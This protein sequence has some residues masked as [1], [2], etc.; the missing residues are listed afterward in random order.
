MGKNKNIKKVGKK[1][2]KK[3]V[4]KPDKKELELMLKVGE[5]AR[6]LKRDRKVASD[7][8]IGRHMP[9]WSE[10]GE[11]AYFADMNELASQQKLE[12][13]QRELEEYRRQKGSSTTTH[14]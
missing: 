2:N 10:E 11:R 6:E 12:E 3:I 4:E 8:S 13:A 1:K 14:K 9:S 5:C 7:A